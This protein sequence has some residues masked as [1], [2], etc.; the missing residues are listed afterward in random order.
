MIV[1]PL[2]CSNAAL[3]GLTAQNELAAPSSDCLRFGLRDL[4]DIRSDVSQ[5][6]ADIYCACSSLVL[7]ICLWHGH[8]FVGRGS[9]ILG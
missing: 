8:P 1:R 9:K 6:I 2:R 7:T 5:C 3:V 4:L